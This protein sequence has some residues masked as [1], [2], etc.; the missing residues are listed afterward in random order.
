[1]GT[2]AG[3]SEASIGGHW[4]MPSLRQVAASAGVSLATAARVAN[5]AD[6]VTPATRARVERAMRELLYVPHTRQ[7]TVATLGLLVPELAN[8]I[9][10]SF[11]QA[12][13]SQATTAGYA[14]ILC[15]TQGSAEHEASY[16]QMLLS[17]RVEGLIFISGEATDLRGSHQHYQ[18]LIDAGARLVFV[19][20][21]VATLDVAS[22]GVD[23]QAA[24]EL[25]AQH[26]LELGHRKIGFIAGPK[27]ARPAR[28]KELGIRNGL[29]AGGVS[30][31]I[32]VA[33]A[34]WGFA[35]GRE[36][37]SQLLGAGRRKAPT[38]VICASDVMALGALRA[39]REAGLDVPGDLSIIGFDG[40][41]ASQWA[42]PPL[43]TLNQ[44]IAEIAKAAVD[45]LRDLLEQPA[46][47]LS[48]HS[49]RPQLVVR[50]STASPRR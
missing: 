50:E 30:A 19:N 11:A 27:H 3:I 33:H 38:A 18:R 45:A 24:G 8:P 12:M 16:V 28:D 44:P 15:N 13:E 10:P 6:H 5:G 21:A 1:M 25:A 41:E 49:F 35:G 39:S 42:E 20:G 9:F 26:L 14:T 31:P 46:R 48:H 22:V 4:Q 7:Q 36:A 43:T 17:R 34:P 29:A 40:I 2:D 32:A 47:P 37:M 23:E